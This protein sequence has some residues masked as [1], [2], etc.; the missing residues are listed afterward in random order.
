MYFLFNICNIYIILLIER[1]S[2]ILSSI[3]KLLHKRIS[4]NENLQIRTEQV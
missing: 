2:I 4:G 3:I 1:N